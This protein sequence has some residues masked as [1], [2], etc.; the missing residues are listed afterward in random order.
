MIVEL[1][2]IKHLGDNE[3]AQLLN[4]LKG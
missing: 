2:A 1:K 3:I 4:Y